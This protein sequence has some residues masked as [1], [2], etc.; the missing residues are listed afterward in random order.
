MSLPPTDSVAAVDHGPTAAAG[1]RSGDDSS[2]LGLGTGTVSRFPAWKR[3]LDLAFGV[4]GL[5]IAAAVAGVV[6]AAMRATGDDGPVFYRAVRVGEGGTPFRIVKL[7]T[8]RTGAS[9]PG[10]TAA[11]DR[12]IT[13]LGRRLRRAKLDELPQLWNVV[14][15]QMSLVGPR[16]EDPRFV[17]W[18]DPLHRLVFTARPGITGLA[19]IA[20]RN[21]EAMVPVADTEQVYRQRILPAKILYDAEYLRHRSLRAD[22]RIIGGTLSALAG[23]RRADRTDSG[24][25]R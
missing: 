6:A 22:L 19:Q 4:P 25:S 18:S 12:R 15:G 5:V 10:I 24:E 20:Y 14:R 7:R 1:I 16:P 17:D 9:G 13:P 2:R 8:M 3:G 23:R 21:E 11:A